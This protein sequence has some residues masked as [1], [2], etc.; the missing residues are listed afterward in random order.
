MSLASTICRYCGQELSFQTEAEPFLIQVSCHRCRYVTVVEKSVITSLP[1]QVY[2]RF[3]PGQ[4]PP[5]FEPSEDPRTIGSYLY[6]MAGALL[7]VVI[8]RAQL[9][10]PVARSSLVSVFSRR[11]KLMQERISRIYQF[12]PSIESRMFPKIA[13]LLWGVLCHTGGLSPSMIRNFSSRGVSRFLSWFEPIA[14]ELVTIAGFA[15]NIRRGEVQPSFDGVGFTFAKTS[16]HTAM[17]ESIV[18]YK[19]QQRYTPQVGS[20]DEAF[21]REALESQRLVLGFNAADITKL[22]L[23]G[24]EQLKTYT[25]VVLERNVYWIRVPDRDDGIRKLI[26][27]CTL[28]LSRLC[29]FRFPLFFDCGIRANPPISEREAI[30]NATAINWSVY[31]PFCST[32]EIEGEVNYVATSRGIVSLFLTSLETQKNALTDQLIV[33]F[34]QACVTG[35]SVREPERI[36]VSLSRISRA[37]IHIV[38][39]TVAEVV[40]DDAYSIQPGD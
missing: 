2:R 38:A 37:G 15:T 35:R 30:L 27:S 4:R 22:A 7:D 10:L 31:Y 32:S 18:N 29:G 11:E 23:N 36:W 14:E 5:A 34:Q 6:T 8:E 26:L 21:S 24:F 13:A 16:R 40:A 28:T 3:L 33:R 12:D 39:D 9:D 1:E 20:L 25:D 17:I 19:Q